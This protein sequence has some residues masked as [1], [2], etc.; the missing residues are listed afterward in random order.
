ML[1]YL[2][3]VLYTPIILMFFPVGYLNMYQFNVTNAMTPA[4]FIVIHPP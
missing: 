3:S 2:K 1:F 4:I